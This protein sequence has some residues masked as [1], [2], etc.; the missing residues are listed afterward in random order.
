MKTCPFC[1]E[2]IQDAAKVCKHCHRDLT[3]SIQQVQVVPRTTPVT[4]LLSGLI[5]IVF[6]TLFYKACFGTMV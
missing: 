6:A 1:A 2:D 3:G 5:A 4:W